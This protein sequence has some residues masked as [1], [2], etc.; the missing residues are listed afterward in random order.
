MHALLPPSPSALPAADCDCL[1]WHGHLRLRPG[2]PRPHT[3]AAPRH[4]LLPRGRAPTK[5]VPAGRAQGDCLRIKPHSLCLCCAVLCCWLR[6]CQRCNNMQGL[7]QPVALNY[8]C[9]RPRAQLCP[10]GF[11]PARRQHALPGPTC[12]TRPAAACAA[13][14][15][16]APRRF[17]HSRTTM[18]TSSQACWICTL[19]VATSRTCRHVCNTAGWQHSWRVP[20]IALEMCWGPEGSRWVAGPLAA[21]PLAN[22][23]PRPC[24]HA[25]L[26]LP[27]LPLARRACYA[28]CACSGRCS[29][30]ARWMSCSGMRRGAATS[31]TPRGMPPS[32]CA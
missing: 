5:G 14:S 29:C 12:T 11:L 30:R 21:S 24:L 16:A 19:P 7:P 23:V 20:R 1:E 10:P 22:L 6:G 26:H 8:S 31:A 9:A 32:C 27:P 28:C 15:C 2:L 3:G 17:R 13:P 25:A 18:L 4:P